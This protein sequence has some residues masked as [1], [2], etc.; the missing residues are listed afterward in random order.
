M[1]YFCTPKNKSRNSDKYNKRPI[2]P[3]KYIKHFGTREGYSSE[4][5]VLMSYDAFLAHFNDEDKSEVRW[6]GRLKNE[7][8]E[9]EDNDEVLSVKALKFTTDD[10]IE[11]GLICNDTYPNFEISRDGK[12]WKTWND[13]NNKYEKQTINQ[14]DVLY[15]R[16]NNPSGITTVHYRS[17]SFSSNSANENSK[18][19]CEGNIMH[20]LSYTEDLDVI[21]CDNCFKSMF[22][23]CTHL[24]K[25][26]NLPATTITTNC[27]TLMFADCVN[28]VDVPKVLPATTIYDQC[29]YSMFQNCTSLIE[30]PYLPATILASQCYSL[31]FQGC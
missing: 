16:G 6:K 8:E 21:P 14:G 30:A 13:G 31:M 7:N 4:E 20:L 10:E 27:Y 23:G 12:N 25:A 22:R 28:L 26:P 15:V 5:N 19:F 1:Q 17:A 24:V 29:Y 11:I 18:L 9:T 2:V 3:M